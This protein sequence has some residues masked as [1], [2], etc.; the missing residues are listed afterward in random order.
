MSFLRHGQICQSDVLSFSSPKRGRFR[1]RP[2]PIVL[3]S[4]RPAIPWQV[5]LEHLPASALPAGSMMYP[6][7]ETVN[8]HLT[9]AEEFSTGRMGN[10]QPEFDISALWPVRTLR[11]S[12]ALDEGDASGHLAFRRTLPR[13]PV[14]VFPKRSLKE[15]MQNH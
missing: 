12:P 11:F 3:I 6:P 15:N 10:L 13:E 7:A 1:L 2:G 5:A 14:S 4:L 8:H 9:R